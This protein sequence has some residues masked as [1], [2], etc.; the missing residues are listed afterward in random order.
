MA[1]LVAH[2]QTGRHSSLQRADRPT[3]STATH[4]GAAAALSTLLWHHDLID[5]HMTCNFLDRT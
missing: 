2:I 5:L 3:R 1:V 4:I